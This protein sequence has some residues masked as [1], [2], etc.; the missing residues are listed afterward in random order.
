MAWQP[1]SLA[2]LSGWVCIGGVSA[3]MVVNAEKVF[4]CRTEGSL[5]WR[6]PTAHPMA[7]HK[8]RAHLRRGRDGRRHV[9]RAHVVNRG[10]TR[11]RLPSRL[12]PP[13]RTAPNPSLRPPVA[14]VAHREMLGVRYTARLSRPNATCPVCGAPVYFYANEY[15][16]RVFFDELGP[17]WP[18][19]PCTDRLASRGRGGYVRSVQPQIRSLPDVR[20][21]SSGSAF[22]PFAV[23][24]SAYANRYGTV[25]AEAWAVVTTTTW[26]VSGTTVHLQRA[27]QI[28]S[29]KHVHLRDQVLL[30]AGSLIFLERDEL[31]FFD[32][33]NMRPVRLRF[34]AGAHPRLGARIL[35][36]LARL[37][38]S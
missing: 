1:C 22:R 33:M 16:S 27:D 35:Q 38:S 12:V 13:R 7:R 23:G 4:T 14:W 36:A 37:F 10:A 25:P 28:F 6:S 2:R 15:G 5:V 32:C 9:V 29:S 34:E 21:Y 30:F 24:A 18:K 26:D 3:S 17:P 19:H 8:R 20:R 31:C 11:P